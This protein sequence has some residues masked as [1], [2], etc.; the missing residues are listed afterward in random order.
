MEKVS[1]LLSI[2]LLIH[3]CSM[4][5]LARSDKNLNT[6]QSALLAFR[7]HI[8]SDPE[9]VLAKNWSSTTSVFNWIGVSCGLTHQR[10]TALNLY[11]MGLKGTITPHLGNLSFLTSLDISRNNFNDYIPK[12]IGKLSRLKV[13]N[14]SFNKLTGFIPSSIFNNSSLEM[15]V[16][17]NN[18]LSGSLPVDICSH[19]PELELLYLSLNQFNGQIPSNLYRCRKLQVLSLSFNEFNGSILREIENLTMLKE[20][21]LTKNSL[22]DMISISGLSRENF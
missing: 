22:E 19:L 5:C 16:L 4:L 13:L 2:A 6:D 8:N 15:I 7:A 21:Y 10:V 14:L 3:C 12:E 11:D 17:T 18:S 1:F 20:L 9:D